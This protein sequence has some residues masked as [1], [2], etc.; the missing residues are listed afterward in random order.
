MD[1]ASRPETWRYQDLPGND[2]LIVVTMIDGWRQTA[3]ARAVGIRLNRAITA[4]QGGAFRLRYGTLYLE[5][6]FRESF[7]AG[8]EIERPRW[9]WQENPALVPT[10]LNAVGCAG[11]TYSRG[12]ALS[13]P[14]YTSQCVVTW[15]QT[16]PA[17]LPEIVLT[18]PFT[19]AEVYNG[20]T[21][22]KL[23]FT[24]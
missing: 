7:K 24:A 21:S 8:V 12:I 20:T 17:A 15:K 22:S 6:F 5:G 14:R 9:R 13:D 3:S 11:K 19:P 1:L 16:L 4:P 10:I 2:A 18:P 23:C